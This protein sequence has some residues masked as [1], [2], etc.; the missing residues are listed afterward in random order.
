[1]LQAIHHVAIICAD[2]QRSKHFYH[3]LLGLP[4]WRNIIALSASPISWICYYRMV[5][6]WSCFLL[7]GRRHGPVGRKRKG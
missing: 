2:Y 7:S 6:N 5:H 1:M 3:Q 4:S